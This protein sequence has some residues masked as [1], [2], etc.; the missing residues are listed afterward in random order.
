ML[1]GMSTRP[2]TRMIHLTDEEVA[3]LQSALDDAERILRTPSYDPQVQEWAL[4][5]PSHS[6][7]TV[8]AIRHALATSSAPDETT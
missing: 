6:L 7:Q 3:F 4:R 8:A 5:H 1:S 2:P